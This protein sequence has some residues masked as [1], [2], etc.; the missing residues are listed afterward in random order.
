MESR[1]QHLD[2]SRNGT[3]LG[4]NQQHLDA[5]AMVTDSDL[6][7]TGA[8]H[9]WAS[10]LVFCHEGDG[11]D[12]PQRLQWAS[13]DLARVSFTGVVISPS[14]HKMMIWGTG[15]FG[16]GGNILKAKQNGNRTYKQTLHAYV[17]CSMFFL[18]FLFM[19]VS[20]SLLS[21]YRS[22]LAFSDTT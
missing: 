6:Y 18:L 12:M 15:F 1:Y 19:M 14:P 7:A 11:I 3:M 8:V 2:P 21:V 22:L 4:G 10:K 13:F 9:T 17:F 5:F 20:L 16:K